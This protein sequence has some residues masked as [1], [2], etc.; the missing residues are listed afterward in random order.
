MHNSTTIHGRHKC[1]CSVNER[2]TQE[3]LIDRRGRYKCFLGIEITHID[4]KRLKLSQPLLIDSIIYLLNIDTNDYDMDTSAKST[5]VGKPLLHKDLS[6]K[7][8]K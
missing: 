8:C 1:F 5:P 4:E 7:P 6:E 3:I 2:R